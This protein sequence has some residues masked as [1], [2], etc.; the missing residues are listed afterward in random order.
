MQS[1]A[2]GTR[3]S[4]R[5]S[6]RWRHLGDED[7]NSSREIPVTLARKNFAGGAPAAFDLFAGRQES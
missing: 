3:D 6:L 5:V 4:F 7:A 2:K 1:G